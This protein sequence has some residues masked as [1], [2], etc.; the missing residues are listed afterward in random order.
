[1]K[2]T[3][4]ICLWALLPLC[5]FAQINVSLDRECLKHN[6]AIMS[7]VV[8]ETF[9]ADSVKHW[10]DNDIRIT[11]LMRVDSLGCVLKIEHINANKVLLPKNFVTTIEN[12]LITNH[13][14]FTM[15]YVQDPPDL[16]MDIVVNSL[17]TYFK[18]H[19][20]KIIPIFWGVLH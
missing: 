1:M 3:I 17:R 19:N 5:A 8:M 4:M 9:G 11:L 20:S 15:Y 18:S 13:V 16:T 2:K 6:A 14:C 7:Q 12:Y 10:L